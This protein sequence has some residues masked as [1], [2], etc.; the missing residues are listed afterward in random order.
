[1][2]P[3]VRFETKRKGAYTFFVSYSTLYINNNLLCLKFHL[4]MKSEIVSNGIRTMVKY[5]F[6]KKNIRQRIVADK[7]LDKEPS[8]SLRKLE[9]I[10]RR[11]SCKTRIPEMIP[12]WP[13][14]V[15]IMCLKIKAF[16]RQNYDN[17]STWNTGC[18][19]WIQM[20]LAPKPVCLSTE[21]QLE[22][23][24]CLLGPHVA[25]EKSCEKGCQVVARRAGD[26]AMCEM[27]PCSDF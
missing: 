16:V 9:L 21:G 26:G 27:R 2:Y 19:A 12:Y 7:I 4:D 23:K 10:Q 18:S 14:K 11:P 22:G 1:M 24:R 3:W 5:F 20:V 17:F 6:V 15:K 8:F 13:L 25:R